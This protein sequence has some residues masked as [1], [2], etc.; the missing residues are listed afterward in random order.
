MGLSRKTIWT[1]RAV[2]LLFATLVSVGCQSSS[3]C[4]TQLVASQSRLDFHGLE[5]TRLLTDV[6]ASGASPRSWEQRPLENNAIYTHRQ[7]RSP[8]GYT[9]VGIVFVHLPLP[10]GPSAVLWLAEQH[11]SSMPGQKGRVLGE[12]TDAVGRSWFTALNPKCQVCGYI[13][14]QGSCAWIVYFACKASGELHPVEM[15]LAARAVESI[16]PMTDAREPV[17]PNVADATREHL[18][19]VP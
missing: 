6:S 7:W 15:S 3:V 4:T 17:G 10:V 16:V 2:A 1:F 13:M 14:T 18:A 5:S 8:T 19:P 11:F 9:G 12:W